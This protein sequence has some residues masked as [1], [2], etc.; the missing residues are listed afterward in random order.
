LNDINV[1]AK[2]QNQIITYYCFSYWSLFLN[3]L[4]CVPATGYVSEKISGNRK[5]EF[6]KAGCTSNHEQRNTESTMLQLC[7][8]KAEVTL[9][10]HAGCMQPAYDRRRPA[11]RRRRPAFYGVDAGMTIVIIR[12]E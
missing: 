2:T 5:T 10:T 7:C 11:C 4:F 12:R 8:S 1:Q 9:G 3:G 6:S